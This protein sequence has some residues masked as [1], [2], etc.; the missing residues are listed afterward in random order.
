MSILSARTTPKPAD[1]LERIWSG[2]STADRHVLLGHDRDTL[3][4]EEKMRLAR[5]VSALG[6]QMRAKST[7]RRTG[8]AGRRRPRT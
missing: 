4:A 7:I 6:R 5:V 1:R 8:T 3:T 2:L